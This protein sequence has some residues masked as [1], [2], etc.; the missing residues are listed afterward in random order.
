M[1]P[2]APQKQKAQQC[3]TVKVT[4]SLKA[5]ES[6]H[7]EIG[8]LTFSVRA[9]TSQERP[10]GWTFSIDNT[11]GDDFIA[12]VKI[13]L[14]F[15]PSQILGPGYGLTARDSLKSIR[16]LRFLINDSDYE[17]VAP[18]WRD[19]L[20]PYSAPDP[21]K[22]ADLYTSALRRIPLGMLRLRI[23]QADVSPEDL[24]R[25]ASFEAEFIVPAQFG[26]APSL[27][28]RSSSCPSPLKP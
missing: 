15:N 2:P 3:S 8:N 19:A 26:L 14:R 4:F 1:I 18:L 13:P 5:G 6:F 9:D 28:P 23:L 10:N 17:L 24:I 20:W 27:S 22:A 21:E 25:S 11:Y 16:E 12:P 7:K